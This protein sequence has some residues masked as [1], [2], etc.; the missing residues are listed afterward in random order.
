MNM[1]RLTAGVLLAIAATVGCNVERTSDPP[2]PSRG[3]DF[4]PAPDPVQA[5]SQGILVT[6][7][8]MNGQ[9]CECTGTSGEKDWKNR[10]IEEL[11]KKCPSGSAPACNDT[12]CT[13]TMGLVSASGT[14]SSQCGVFSPSRTCQCD[15]NCRTF[16][17]C[18]FD[19][20]T[21]CV[22]CAGSCGSFS[23]ARG[24]QCDSAC[25]QFGDCCFDYADQCLILGGCS[26][27]VD[28]KEQGNCCASCG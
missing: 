25:K 4:T 2:A 1:N 6:S 9:N 5:V 21:L 3:P 20:N 15:S 18:C 26:C 10:C 27:A 24:C 11:K 19:H 12:R 28:C 13:C 8:S 7:C 22:S 17:D 14:C 16:G 23:S